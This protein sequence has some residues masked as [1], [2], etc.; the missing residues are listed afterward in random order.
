M[1]EDTETLLGGDEEGYN[2][3][4]SQEDADKL[5]ADEEDYNNYADY[6]A[7]GQWEEG[8]GAEAE[9]EGEEIAEQGEESGADV[10]AQ[11]TP[12][13]ESKTETGDNKKAAANGEKNH[14]TQQYYHRGAMRGGR[15]MRLPFPPRF[16]FGPRG[17]RPP[18]FMMRPGMRPPPGMRPLPPGFRGRLP[19]PM[20]PRMRMRFPPRPPF[21]PGHPLF[22][23]PPPGMM[24][25]LRP[26]MRP[27]FPPFGPPH[28][29]ME[30]EWDEEWE[31]EEEEDPQNKKIQ[32]V[33]AGSGGDAKNDNRKR[34]AD[35]HYNNPYHA[36]KRGRGTYHQVSPAPRGGHVT[37]V[38]GG[39][40]HHVTTYNHHQ[41]HASTLGG[42]FVPVNNA[43]PAH[44]AS[45]GQPIRTVTAAAGGQ[46]H[47]NL[48]TIQ[49]TDAPPPVASPLVQVNT[50]PAGLHHL[51]RS[52]KKVL[53][54]NLPSSISYDKI[55]Q[56]AIN[57]GPI[58]SLEFK[59]HEK[60]AVIEFVSPNSAELFQR[61]Q[62]RK[63]M[64]LAIITVSRLL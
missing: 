56:M 5:L 57:Y 19:M 62:N 20:H 22:R 43:A 11:A 31:E 6:A 59:T 2:E 58:T 21:P 30:G 47:S 44:T 7:D 41:S 24:R 28:M 46:C 8:E 12:E 45:Y 40:H 16:P 49:C 64:D 39:G 38:R 17:V 23:P 4:I 53:V 37:P 18:P 36:A 1:S 61:T 35:Q 50:A 48:R 51:P 15:M 55:H 52:D 29:M 42:G 34:P 13:T 14:P 26:G 60:S 9:A 3:E 10:E 27:P 32:T 33:I 63:M 25:P 54:Q